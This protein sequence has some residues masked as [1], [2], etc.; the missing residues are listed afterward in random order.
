MDGD[1]GRVLYSKNGSE[2]LANASTTKILTCIIA[3][4][5]CD[6]ADFI[7]N[8][9]QPEI[10]VILPQNQPIFTSGSHHSIWVF[11]A[12]CYQVIDQ[13]SNIRTCPIQNHRR[14]VLCLQ[15]SVDS[16]NNSLCCSFFIARRA[17]KLPSPIQAMNLFC[18]QRWTQGCWVYAI[19]FNRISWTHDFYMFQAPNRPQECKLHIFWQRRSACGWFIRLW[20]RSR[21]WC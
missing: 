9:H 12:L 13:R 18:F 17:V 7:T 3:L 20:I 10:C 8:R 21:I 2:A 5:N 19:I 4:E 15:S 16:G 11:T 1:S 6:L 14:F